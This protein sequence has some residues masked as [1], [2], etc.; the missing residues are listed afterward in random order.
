MAVHAASLFLLLR[1]SADFCPRVRNF[2]T[3]GQKTKSRSIPL[4]S[5]NSNVI[6][7]LSLDVGTK[8][9]RPGLLATMRAP[10]WAKVDTGQ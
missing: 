9:P 6:A 10:T 7:D 1:R 3:G 8:R 2:F 4:G 5:R